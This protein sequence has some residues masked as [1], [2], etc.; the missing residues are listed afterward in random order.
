[1]NYLVMG[2]HTLSLS[3]F[4]APSGGPHSTLVGREHMVHK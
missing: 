3:G 2:S 4:G 1:M